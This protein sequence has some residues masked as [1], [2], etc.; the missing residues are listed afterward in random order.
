MSMI[1]SRNEPKNG[2]RPPDHQTYALTWQASGDVMQ[3]KVTIQS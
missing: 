1:A 3:E 2:Q